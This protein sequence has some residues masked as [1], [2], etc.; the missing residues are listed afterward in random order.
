MS[1][2]ESPGAELRGRSTFQTPKAPPDVM[3]GG[4][5]SESD[6]VTTL[7]CEGHGLRREGPDMLKSASGGNSQPAVA[8]GRV[9]NVELPGH[10]GKVQFQQS[11]TGLRVELPT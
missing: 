5:F 1:D 9:S 11:A 7:V 6:S 8:P 10:R 2:D 4:A 3:S